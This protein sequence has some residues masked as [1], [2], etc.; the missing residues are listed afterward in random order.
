M[1]LWKFKSL[2]D[3]GLLHVLQMLATNQVFLPNCELVNDSKEGQWYDCAP[4]RQT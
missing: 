1:K 2:S 3:K 4:P